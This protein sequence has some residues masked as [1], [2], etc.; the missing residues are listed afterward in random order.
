VRADFHAAGKMDNHFGV[1]IARM[2]A[3]PGVLGYR[4]DKVIDL[5][6]TATPVASTAQPE[7]LGAAQRIDP[8]C[9]SRRM[10][11]RPRCPDAGRGQ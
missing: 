8:R 3:I 4:R 7:G 10:K 5:K 2:P 6:G 9:R 1:S 11:R